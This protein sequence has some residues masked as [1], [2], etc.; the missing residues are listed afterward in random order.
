MLRVFSPNSGVCA[1][2]FTLGSGPKSWSRWW[3]PASVPALCAALPCPRLLPY[4]LPDEYLDRGVKGCSSVYYRAKML[5]VGS[6]GKGL[7]EEEHEKEKE[8]VEE[9]GGR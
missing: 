6:K 7:A 4:L 3:L 5:G 2:L 1:C 9:E 8:D